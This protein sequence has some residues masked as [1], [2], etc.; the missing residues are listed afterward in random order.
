MHGGHD[1]RRKGRRDD[2]SALRRD[3]ELPAEQ[4]LGRGRAEADDGA[5]LDQLDL[6]VE[7][8]PAGGDLARVRLLVDAALPARLPLEMLH[9][10]GDVDGDRS[11][12]AA[13]SARSSSLPA[14]PTNGCPAMSSA[15]PGCS[16]MSISDAFGAPSPKTVWVACLYRS[17]AW[18]SSRRHPRSRAWAGRESDQRP[19]VG[20]EF[21]AAISR[22]RRSPLIFVRRMALP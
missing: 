11:I 8:G 19:S 12:P 15:S 7:P 21:L 18:H 3:L 5:R 17:H 4:R 1:E 22:F 14:G 2:L 20:C 16:P 10:V 13:S 9:D 6:G